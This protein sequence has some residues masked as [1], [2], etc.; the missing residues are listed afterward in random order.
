MDKDEDEVVASRRS[1]VVAT[2]S[3]IRLV[4]ASL[5]TGLYIIH[6]MMLV[7]T[8]YSVYNECIYNCLILS[9]F[10]FIR[11]HRLM[12]QL[13]KTNQ[14]QTLHHLRVVHKNGEKMQIFDQ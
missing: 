13:H 5:H 4:S 3:S 11:K 14:Q 7:C 10:F 12:R 1:A 8:A 2:S 6:T 9:S